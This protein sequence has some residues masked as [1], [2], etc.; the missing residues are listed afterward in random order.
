MNFLVEKLLLRLFA[1]PLL[2]FYAFLPTALLAAG[3]VTEDRLKASVADGSDWL[4]KGGNARGQHYSVLTQVNTANV[5]ELGLAWATDL[6]APDG[7]A[8]TPIIVDGVIYLSAAY[9]VVYA[10]DAKSGDILWSFD[11]DVRSHFAESPR[12]SW[13]G[14]ASRGI[15][16]W[17]GKVFATT[18]DCRLLALNA[19]TGKSVWSKKTCDP[20]VGYAIS[21]SPYVGDNKVF[22]GNNGSESGEK[23]RGYV[24][25]Y[26][27][28]SGKLIW[29]FYTVPS[30]DPAENTT[31]AMKMAAAT[32][33]GDALAKF[34]GGGNAWNEMT[35]DPETGLL[36]FGTAGALPYVHALRSPKG[37]DNLFLSS[38]LALKAETGEYVWHYQT[39]PKDNWDYNA[40]MNIALAEFEIGGN[41][42]K[43]LL[44]APKNGFHYVLDRLT[45][46]LLAADKFARVNWASHINL[47][48]GRPV[49][50]P[51]AE[52]W[53]RDADPVV[54]VWPNL[55]GAHNWH[56][57]AWHPEHKLT[58]IP[59]IDVPSM[60]SHYEDGD[61]SDT[62]EVITVVDDRPFSPGKLV[63]FDP[64]AGEPRWT[65]E[66]EFPF[67]GGVMTTAGNLV[68]QG[69]AKGRFTAYAAD[70]GDVLWSVTTGSS[71][72]AAP[73]TYSIDG[74]QFIVIPIGSGGGLQFVYPEMHSANDSRGPTRLLAFRLEGDA[75]L[76]IATIISRQL[77][78]QPELDA[79]PETINLGKRFYD[80]KCGSCHGKGAAV[81]FGGSV[82]DLRY[83]NADTHASW[84]AIVIGGSKRGNGMPA[85][86]ISVDESEAVRAYVISRAMEIRQ[87]GDEK[88]VD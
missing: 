23:N 32:W 42:R 11:P 55:W 85:I 83:A 52:Y 57:M 9:S 39:V 77:P 24:S 8:T 68:F 72:S 5:A 13:T 20:N 88:S 63:A 33:S 12:T 26:D 1:S 74:E 30:D 48:T 18:A 7:I 59:V 50:T 47:E 69:D 76:P 3:D 81:R 16:V 61:F 75:A 70:S 6:P 51:E 84:H 17:G 67:N 86:E 53:T 43:T 21:D 78:E 66:H 49:Y 44:I 71:I 62:L 54:A 38:I 35:Y 10:I 14:R 19:E 22:V 79:T 73:A 45:G 2:V 25:A 36:F 87:A 80:W 15:A 58:Y 34:G 65:V 41:V 29:R 46:E 37:G 60:V 82:P 56:P 40:T 27:V 31:P 28:V 64:L 4:V